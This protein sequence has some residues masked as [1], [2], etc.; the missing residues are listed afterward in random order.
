MITVAHAMILAALGC[1]FNNL[2]RTTMLD[3]VAWETSI[4]TD[5][6]LYGTVDSYI[7]KWSLKDGSVAVAF[8]GHKEKIKSIYLSSNKDTLLSSSYP[9]VIGDIPKPSKDTSV[10]VWDVDSGQEIAQ[11]ND[12]S[13]GLWSLDGKSVFVTRGYP[14]GPFHVDKHM[15]ATG[16]KLSSMQIEDIITYGDIKKVVS[17]DRL[18][19][20]NGLFF[21]IYDLSKQKLTRTKYKLTAGQYYSQFLSGT[22]E[23]M[24]AAD[25]G[26][27]L[28]VFSTATGECQVECKLPLDAGSSR[29]LLIPMDSNGRLLIA[30]KKSLY[31]YNWKLRVGGRI[32]DFPSNL[33]K[34]WKNPKSNAVLIERDGQFESNPGFIDLV[35]V[36]QMKIVK[37]IKTSHQEKC[38]G[39]SSNGASF[40]IG[41]STLSRFDSSTGKVISS[42]V[43][44][45]PA[46][47]SRQRQ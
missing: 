4:Y 10:R 26:A 37:T 43:L 17:G 29:P 47:G 46:Q 9:D 31:S 44:M 1:T 33:S 6:Y 28:R 35:D 13:N 23:L 5:N 38:L 24:Y 11:F 18:I 40:A 41:G 15:I 25:E 34:M 30:S 8:H 21:S 45:I 42:H 7:Y 19:Q 27:N 39:F 12:A 2:P 36:S 16:E 14:M 20:E 32:M 22:N 3:E